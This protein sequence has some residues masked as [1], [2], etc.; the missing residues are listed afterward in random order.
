[1]QTQDW[2]DSAEPM[3]VLIK[4]IV[5]SSAGMRAAV[6]A[7]NRSEPASCAMDG[8]LREMIGD[9]YS[10]NHTNVTN[11]S[12]LVRELMDSLGYVEAGRGKCGLPGGLVTGVLWRHPSM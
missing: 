9:A 2:M 6:Q 12:W 5:F 1:M 8:L 7:T 10:S 3:F 4:D 11:C